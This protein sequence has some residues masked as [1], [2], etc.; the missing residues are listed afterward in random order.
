[1]Q[2]LA[3]FAAAGVAVDPDAPLPAALQLVA[4]LRWA[5]ESGRIDDG[6]G[7][8]SIRRGAA[9][10]GLHPNTLRKAYARLGE[11]GYASTSQGLA[12]VAVAQSLGKTV[13]LRTIA[14][15]A[16]A[17]AREAGAG[18][19]ELAAAVLAG[20]EGTP[21]EQHPRSQLHGLPRGATIGLVGIRGRAAAGVEREAA[22]AGLRTRRAE[23]TDR[24]ALANLAWSCQLVLLGACANDAA[25][26]R[27]LAG[28][29]RVEPLA[30]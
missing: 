29:P 4:R 1:M 27:W 30:G 9:E 11:Q 5:I 18:P 14:L 16:L 15:D 19:V 3:S 22:H 21:Q 8:P 28:A 20:A 13:E 25:T 2:R 6:E 23:P 24:Y 26:R 7:L 12:T 10:L 17:R